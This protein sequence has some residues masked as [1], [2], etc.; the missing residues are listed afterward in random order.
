VTESHFRRR[1]EPFLHAVPLL[2]S[3]VNAL[4]LLFANHLNQADAV[5]WIAPVPYNCINEADIECIRGERSYLY[6]WIF[7]AGPN[8]VALSCLFAI[9]YKMYMIVKQREKGDSSDGGTAGREDKNDFSMELPK[10][11]ETE[12]SEV[13]PQQQCT[14]MDVKKERSS[15]S[16]IS[17][18]GHHRSDD[19]GSSTSRGA[20]EGVSVHQGS[21]QQ[22]VDDEVQRK[23]QQRQ[24]QIE[25]MKT[26]KI[27]WFRSKEALKQACYFITSFLLCYFWVYLNGAY[28]SIPGQESPYAVRICLWFFFPLQGFFNIIIFIRPHVTVLRQNSKDRMSYMEAAW[29]VV[30][31]GTDI[32]REAARSAASPVL[33]S[34]NKQQQQRAG[35]KRRTEMKLSGK[36]KNNRPVHVPP[37][38]HGTSV[39]SK[40]MTHVDT[41]IHGAG[42]EVSSMG[43]ESFK[44]DLVVDTKEAIVE[45]DEEGVDYGGEEEEMQ[46]IIMYGV[47]DYDI[48]DDDDGLSYDSYYYEDN[49]KDTD[50][51][52]FAP[53]EEG[54]EGEE[55]EES[56]RQAEEQEM[57]KPSWSSNRFLHKY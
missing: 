6:R 56:S 16:I 53:L 48:Y 19:G 9:S 13:N 41:R 52:S 34:G 43:F 44:D 37:S 51:I 39:K 21:N 8:G 22:A 14:N 28:E 7:A 17:S 10:V 38:H 24:Q 3:L 32:S 35:V 12:E 42:P 33:R 30:K 45:D 26:K 50:G 36:E 54:D 47:N 49:Y 2:F 31:S 25:L 23:L 29:K 27:L 18:T 1:I 5:C 4:I 40:P 11:R 46:P 55:D 15:R 57:R 20:G